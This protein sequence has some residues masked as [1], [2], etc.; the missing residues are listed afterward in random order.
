MKPES[1]LEI[2]RRRVAVA[3]AEVL[4]QKLIVEDLQ[5]SGHPAQGSIIL[6]GL[7]QQSLETFRKSLAL[8]EEHNPGSN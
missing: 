1:R 6:L 2:A 7:M 5:K 4:R 3:E 8:M